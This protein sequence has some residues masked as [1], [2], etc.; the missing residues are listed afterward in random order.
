MAEIGVEKVRIGL[1]V[2]SNDPF[3]V[4]VRETIW[5]ACRSQPDLPYR[6]SSGGAR[7][8]ATVTDVVEIEIEAGY[9]TGEAEIAKVEEIL[10]LDLDAF[11]A[12]PISGSLIRRLLDH[13]L[14]V[15]SLVE[16]DLDHPL[17]TCPNG[18]YETGR[19]ACEFLA[20]RLGGRGRVAVIGGRLEA[21]H[22]EHGQSRVQAANDLFARYPEIEVFHLP[23]PWR[24]EECCD[25]LTPLLA[26]FELPLD[27]LFGLSDTIALAARDVGR[28][29]GG[30]TSDTLIVGING[31]PL[32][33]AAIA[34]G[35]MAATVATPAVVFGQEAV[36]LAYRVAA[37]QGLPRSFNYS[38]SLVTAHNVA[39]VALDKLVAIAHMP[40][41]LVGSSRQR[42]E[43]RLSQLE[44]N[45]AVN[46]QIGAILDR[47]ALTH[48][49]AELIRANYGFD[50]VYIYFWSDDEQELILQ[51]PQ[52]IS[53]Q[54]RRIRLAESGALGQTL[55]QN[56]PVVIPD[57]RRSLRY[58]PDPRFP[59]TVA[60][61]TMPIRLAGRTTGVLDM[62]ASHPLP[63][64]PFDLDS[65]QLLADQ[66]GIA[67]RNAQLYS[68]ALAARAEV[69]QA[70]RLKSDLIANVS[71][72]LRT[73]LNIILG[74]CQ[75]VLA[76][77][78]PE[79]SDLPADLTR[80]LGHIQDA[81]QH[82]SYLIND[83]ID[84][85]QVAAGG[86]EIVPEE[87]DLH[88]FL[89]EMFHAFCGQ[90][91]PNDRVRWRL[92]L[93]AR[94]PTLQAD[95]LRLRQI[96]HNLLDNAGKFTDEGHITLGAAAEER[97]IHIWV[98][99]TGI[100]L[101]DEQA[102]QIFDTFSTVGLLDE[103]GQGR[104]GI[105]LGLAVTHHLVRLH[106]GQLRVESRRGHGSTFH[107]YLP[108]GEEPAVAVTEPVSPAAAIE[109]PDSLARAGELVRR[110]AAFISENYATPF[111]R[112][113]IADAIGVS[114]NY[115]SRVFRREIGLSPWQYLTRHRV[116]RAKELLSTTSYPIIEVASQV[117]YTDPAYFSRIFRKET[118]KTPRAYREQGE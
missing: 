58:R 10:A 11:I 84:L 45:L 24:Y 98:A 9:R 68:D 93:P 64:A 80:D 14:P 66:L 99:D 49:I 57:T 105:G 106:R 20:E 65:L 53:G 82:L 6:V 101:G 70:S 13:G 87:L 103:T 51:E 109:G 27:G 1:Q 107:I 74:Y 69:E 72:E 89:C 81:G 79:R 4:E 26:Q 118:G 76:K 18:L 47:D 12:V 108:Q 83:L 37:G 115:I 15:I 5:Q 22:V 78:D 96:L 44:I 31:D 73:P 16:Y 39:E 32:A 104:S 33:V 61:V 38:P 30:V 90:Y 34:K 56:R 59:E 7:N 8:W 110:T 3:W 86:L 75:A 23:A 52:Q 35:S 36:K 42:E 21:A 111:S 19:L 48:E 25:Y 117:G 62:H 54:R 40:S 50:T 97:S 113:E 94:L 102:R 112:Q 41:R 92:E 17:F 71:H 28:T 85:A 60:R 114:P 43:R 91:Q 100:G 55:L 46:R 63:Q 67:I 116:I 88:P 2:S 77:P 95:P 29:Q